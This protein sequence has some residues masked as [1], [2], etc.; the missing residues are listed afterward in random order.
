MPYLLF[1]RKQG[2]GSLTSRITAYGTTSNERLLR[3]KHDSLG[4]I[5]LAGWSDAVGGTNTDDALIMKLNAGGEILWQRLLGNVGTK[6]AALGIDVDSAGNVYIVGWTASAI[7]N[8]SDY[9]VFVAKYNSSGTLLWQRLL[10]GAN[11]DRSYGIGVDGSGNAYVVLSSTSTGSGDYDAVVVKYD[12]SGVLQWQRAIGDANPG[13]GFGI[14]V[15]A[16]GNS[17]LAGYNTYVGTGTDV[18]VVKLDPTGTEVWQRKIGPAT[19]TADSGHTITIDS[20]GNII[21]VGRSLSIPAIGTLDN[22][23]VIK[24]DS[25]GNTVWQRA[26]GANGVDFGLGVTTDSSNNVYVV[27][28]T[29]STGSRDG[30]IVKYDA[31]GNLVWQ[32][33][34]GGS[35]VDQLHGVA[36][37]NT[38]VIVAGFVTS[39]G[40]GGEDVVLARLPADGSKTGTYTL[41]VGSITY[42]TTSLTGQ[43]TTF[44]NDA[45]GL[46]IQ[47]ASLVDQAASFSD[48]TASMNRVYVDL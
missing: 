40:N 32:R 20:S 46:T 30:L 43:T 42:Q 18:V 44:T 24:C 13:W 26:V 22:I 14:A 36:A 8:P 31:S 41:G 15:D 6:E 2:S 34:L 17:Y 11:Y 35:G 3:V 28:Y 47:N 16:G 48:T 12:T 27:G 21:I 23:I 7:S 45:A 33:A 25:S 19:N 4:N 5:Y 10:T 1:Q 9:D 37:T 29:E 38:D 39:M